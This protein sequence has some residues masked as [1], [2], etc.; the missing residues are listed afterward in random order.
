MPKNAEIHSALVHAD[1]A[2]RRR[3]PRVTISVPVILEFTESDMQVMISARTQS[4]NE[5]GAMV[6][7]SRTLAAGTILEVQNERTGMT[8]PGRVTRKPVP[9]RDGYLIPIELTKRAD[10]FWG[11]TFPPNVRHICR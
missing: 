8:S 7:C 5:H 11:I 1:V 10:S 2:E 3:S 4:V 9:N 6:A